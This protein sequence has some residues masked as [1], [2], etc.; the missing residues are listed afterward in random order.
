MQLGIHREHQRVRVAQPVNM[1]DPVEDDAT[2]VPVGRSHHHKVL[3]LHATRQSSQLAVLSLRIGLV[4]LRA[5]PRLH[6]RLAM[7]VRLTPKSIAF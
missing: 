1:D 4:R 7:D 5:M 3:L 6:V 2:K